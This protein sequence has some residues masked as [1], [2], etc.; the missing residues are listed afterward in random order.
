M[1]MLVACGDDDGNSAADAFNDQATYRAIG[2]IGALDRVV[3]GRVDAATDTCTIIR[4]VYPAGAG[5]SFGIATPADWGI[6]M[7]GVSQGASGCLADA[8]TIPDIMS[9]SGSGSIS[10]V[11]S[12]PDIYP[13]S[14]SI[15]ATVVF[16]TG[17]P[18]WVP[19]SIVLRADDLA[20]E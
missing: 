13:T 18:A 19:A 2:L 5:G 9:P 20:V 3:I 11:V 14:V 7:A 4:V 12:P 1:A 8:S 15:D 16:D 10:F 17:A 6:E